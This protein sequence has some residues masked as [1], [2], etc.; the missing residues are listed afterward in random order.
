MIE[1]SQPYAI[2]TRCQ[3]INIGTQ[4][5]CLRCQTPLPARII[6]KA[7]TAGV[8]LASQAQDFDQA[9]V[10]ASRQLSLRIVNGPSAGHR[11]PL[12]ERTSLGSQTENT[13][14]LVDRLAS[15]IH[16][17]IE[18]KEGRYVLSDLNS[19]NGSYINGVRCQKPTSLSP[20][21]ELV[22]GS[23]RIQVELG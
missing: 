7:Q 10:A 13:I 2:C 3:S 23:T 11:F 19:T 22:I 9:T 12:G 5:K 16:A 20:G 6:P 21:M 17:L 14:V 15:R 8:P 1:P 18:L 4:Q